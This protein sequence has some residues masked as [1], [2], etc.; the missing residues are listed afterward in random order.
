MQY[1]SFGSLVIVVDFLSDELSADEILV[2][3]VELEELFVG[4]TLADLTLLHDNDLVGVTNS[5]ESMCHDDD[6]LL[7]TVDE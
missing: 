1:L 5:T 2:N 3:A 4:A 6:G 7:A